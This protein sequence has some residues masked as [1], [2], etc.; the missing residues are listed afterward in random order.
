[1]NK[2][3]ILIGIAIFAFLSSWMISFDVFEEIYAYTRVYE[4]WELDELIVIGLSLIIGLLSALLLTVRRRTKELEIEKEMSFNASE[5]KTQMI[6]TVN[7]ELRTPLTSIKGAVGFLAN[8]MAQKYD[9][10]TCELLELVERNVNRLSALIEDTLSIERIIDQ[11]EEFDFTDVNANQL[12]QTAFHNN[13]QSGSDKDISLT[14]SGSGADIVLAVDE[15]RIMQIY[16]NLIA[17]SLRYSNQGDNLLL[18]CNETEQSVV[19]FVED[20][21]PGIPKSFENHV[22]ERLSRLNASGVGEIGGAGLGLSI[23][24][25]IAEAHGG[26]VWFESEPGVR[27]TFYFELPKPTR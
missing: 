6:I 26:S 2:F 25:A 10:S 16:G 13:R 17:N 22:F 21:G 11:V 1:M 7:H 12:V 5:A 9:K 27:T 18:G 23:S 19:F 14:I 3:E 15:N 20:H 24:K 4:E 8:N